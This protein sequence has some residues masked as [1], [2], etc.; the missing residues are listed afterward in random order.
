MTLGTTLRTL[1]DW[2]NNLVAEGPDFATRV[3][4]RT[5]GTDIFIGMIV[6]GSAETFPDID[7][8]AEDEMPLGIVEGYTNKH[9][10]DTQ[11]YWYRDGDVPFG[12]NKWV[13]VGQLTPTQVIW[14]CSA[15]NTTIAN[16][17]PL[18]VVDGL[19]TNATTGDDIIG[20]AEEAVTGASSTTKYFRMRVR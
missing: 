15:S 19:M 7:P 11:G 1:T 18:K 5:N 16:G 2:K 17:A 9:E 6:T 3:E 20:V 14:V 4:R 8:C 10:I 13:I 12:D